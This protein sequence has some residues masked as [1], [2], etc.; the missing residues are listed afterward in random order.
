[1]NDGVKYI[2]YLHLKH[3]LFLCDNTPDPLIWVR[4]YSI[5]SCSPQQQSLYSDLVVNV[6]IVSSPQPLR[7]LFAELLA[8]VFLII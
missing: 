2:Y 5:L 8:T 7:P 6:Y 1:M 4:L 3:W